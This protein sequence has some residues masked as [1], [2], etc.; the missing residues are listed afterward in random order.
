[1]NKNIWKTAMFGAALI[2]MLGVAIAIWSIDE[3]YNI[4]IYLG[5]AIIA[6]V[7]MAWWIWVMF[8]IRTVTTQHEKTRAELTQVREGITQIKQLVQ[9][10]V[11]LSNISDRQ[12]RK[13][14]DS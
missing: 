14:K 7:C 3:H 12:R 11:K 9:D 4:G 2:L 6:G 1:M 10:Y 13:S 5:L 8:I